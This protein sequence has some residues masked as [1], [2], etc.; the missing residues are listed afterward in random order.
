VG[1]GC[2]G[3][4]DMRPESSSSPMLLVGL[5]YAASRE[6]SCLAVIDIY[7]D[8]REPAV[9]FSVR[10]GVRGFEVAGCASD[11]VV[12][13][14]LGIARPEGVTGIIFSLLKGVVRPLNIDD[15][16]RNRNPDFDDA[17]DGVIRPEIA[18]V[19]RSPREEATEEDR[20]T[21]P[22]PTVG[23]ESLTV[24]TKT[25]QFSGHVK[26]CF[27]ENQKVSAYTSSFRGQKL[28]IMV[29]GRLAHLRRSCHVI[30]CFTC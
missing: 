26:Y 8:A 21:A 10:E 23:G 6:L 30:D 4:E 3:E 24:D 15:D 2:E 19:V 7:F 25:P 13:A 1:E 27:L 14:G 12:D 11:R 16:P 9:I 20:C 18:G 22:G 17:L 28:V 5:L 29:S